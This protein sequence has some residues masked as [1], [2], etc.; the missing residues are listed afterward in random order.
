MYISIIF[1]LAI[2]L[3]PFLIVYY[4][5]MQICK[6]TIYED[7]SSA[8][9]NALRGVAAL[10]ITIHHSV[11]MY[12]YTTSGS[13]NILLSNGF[14]SK[15]STLDKTILLS[16]GYIP[17]ML[18]FM[19]TGFLFFGKI[20]KN[21]K[22]NIP[23]FYKKRA[24]RIL[25]LYF[26]MIALM[27]LT[28]YIIGFREDVTLGFFIKDIIAWLTFG[29]IQPNGFTSS[30]PNSLIV[31][32]VIWTLVYE[33]FFYALLPLFSSFFY[34]RRSYL[35]F[36]ALMFTI[37]ILLFC[38]DF[39]NEINTT[40]LLCFWCGLACNIIKNNAT[41]LVLKILKGNIFTLISLAA[42]V[43]SVVGSNF[44]V[45]KIN[46]MFPL[47]FVFLS[48]CLGSSIFGILKV[49]PLQISGTASYSIYLLHGLMLSLAFYFIKGSYVLSTNLALFTASTLSIV[50]YTYIERKF[51]K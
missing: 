34:S 43:I 4:S 32:G 23:L 31:C 35:T 46:V 47:F 42:L 6:D 36:A 49:K 27:I 3:T 1:S 50:T 21:P 30:F 51:I 38:F 33:W 28:S 20:I 17:V 15:S 7:N 10:L 12:N 22:L 19:I 26:T 29:M 44:G 13:W 39:I 25:P 48:V 16:F 45:Y 18:F 9:I 40:L 8:Y 24:R 2:A 37:I 41:K 14:F 5:N 11:F